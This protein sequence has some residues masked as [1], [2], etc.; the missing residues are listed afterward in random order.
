MD[1]RLAW[2][3]FDPLV[4]DIQAFKKDFLDRALQSQIP[5]AFVA[6]LMAAAWNKGLELELGKKRKREGGKLKRVA[7]A[8]LPLVPK[9]RELFAEMTK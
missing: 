5:Q 8:L 4:N 2:S 9:H 7:K 3:Q 1:Y 6:R